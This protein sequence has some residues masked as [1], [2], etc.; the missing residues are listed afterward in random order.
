[1]DKSVVSRKASR[2]AQTTMVLGAALFWR[3]YSRKSTG[4]EQ[5]KAMEFDI[6]V[7]IEPV[8]DC[9]IGK[10]GDSSDLNRGTCPHVGLLQ[11]K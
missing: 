1:M 4:V 3:M 7:V 9:N 10:P 2:L 8:A 5:W 11:E 6:S